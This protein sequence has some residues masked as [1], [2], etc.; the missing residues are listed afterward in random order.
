ML[1]QIKKT[2]FFTEV[3]FNV[4]GGPPVVMLWCAPQIPPFRI[5]ALVPPGTLTVDYQWLTLEMCL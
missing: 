1:F 2:C 5:E 3:K 4:H